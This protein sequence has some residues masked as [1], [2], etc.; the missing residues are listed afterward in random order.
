[1][2]HIDRLL[3]S[4]QNQRTR[5]LLDAGLSDTPPRGSLARVATGLGVVVGGSTWSAAAAGAGAM[6][7]TAGAAA[8]PGALTV[9]GAGKLLAIGALAGTLVSGAS[10]AIEQAGAPATRS[11]RTPAALTAPK[12]AARAGEETGARAEAPSPVLETPEPPA[13]APE[14]PAPPATLRAAPSDS[15]ALAAEVA[16]IDAARGALAQ[17]DP[18]RALSELAAYHRERQLGVL[19]REA[20]LLA[21]RAHSELGHQARARELAR[22]YL[23]AHPGD[24]HATR[25]RQLIDEK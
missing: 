21:I 7:S 8:A 2:T 9:L 13:P 19:D 16:R 24:A 20:T 12:L 18:A 3:K 25:L 15:G 5:E 22:D 10:I 1:M 6:A 14:S 4:S 17:G 23:A 11:A